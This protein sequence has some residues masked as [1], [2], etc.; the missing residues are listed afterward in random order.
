MRLYEI[1]NEDGAGAGVDMGASATSYTAAG[2][3]T[4][5][6]PATNMANFAAPE[7]TGAFVTGG[8]RKTGRI[9]LKPISYD[10]VTKKWS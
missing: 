3:P 2:G 6:N 1:L 10:P 8:K 9:P 7:T 5:A 4:P